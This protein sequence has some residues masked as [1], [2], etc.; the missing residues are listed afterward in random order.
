MV[1]K[2]EEK[3]LTESLFANEDIWHYAAV[4][5]ELSEAIAD[6]YGEEDRQGLADAACEA[7]FQEVSDTYVNNPIVKNVAYSA[8]RMALGLKPLP[9]RQ[10]G[11]N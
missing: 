2:Y 8:V 10:E 11:D 9:E 7:A 4:P 6:E 5:A 3:A 1:H